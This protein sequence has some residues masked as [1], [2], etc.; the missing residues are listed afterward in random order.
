MDDGDGR[1]VLSIE[2]CVCGFKWSNGNIAS[3]DLSQPERNPQ[4]R[5]AQRSHGKRLSGRCAPFN[6]ELRQADEEEYRI[7]PTWP[8]HRDVN[9]ILVSY[10][11]IARRY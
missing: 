10:G 11:Y 6:G 8:A 9:S 3:E 7:K 2:C 4:E 1:R 5:V